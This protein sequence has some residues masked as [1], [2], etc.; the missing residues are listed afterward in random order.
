MCTHFAFAVM[1]TMA[2]VSIVAM[3]PLPVRLPGR[4]GLRVGRK[5]AAPRQ[6]SRLGGCRAAPIAALDPHSVA[7]AASSAATHTSNLLLHL[8]DASAEGAEAVAAVAADRS[9]FL[10]TIANGLE[11][12]LEGI[13]GVL[14]GA[15]VPY[16][17]GFSIILLTLLVKVA[18]FPLTKKQMDSQMQMQAIAPRV[19]E[20]QVSGD[21]SPRWRS[22]VADN[23]LQSLSSGSYAGPLR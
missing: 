15:G 8:A 23:P 12:T 7:S 2:S 22:W 9:G 6:Q 4:S 10:N 17:Y 1:Q 16:S 5:V 20:L 19:K 11:A 14:S 18:T 21:V 13:D 3:R